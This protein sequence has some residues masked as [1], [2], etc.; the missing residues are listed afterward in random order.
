MGRGK[1]RSRGRGRVTLTR[2]LTQVGNA[3]KNQNSPARYEEI[4]KVKNEEEVGKKEEV[5][6]ETIGIL[7]LYLVLAQQIMSFLK[8]F[9]G[10]ETQDPTNPPISITIPN[11]VCNC[12]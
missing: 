10:Q 1:M 6:D 5:H 11:V 9:V 12:R 8:G 2:D 4:E 3:R 7:P